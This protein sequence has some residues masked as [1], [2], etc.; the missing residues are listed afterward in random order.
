MSTKRASKLQVSSGRFKRLGY[1]VVQ[2][3]TA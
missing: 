3:G 1:L 2:L